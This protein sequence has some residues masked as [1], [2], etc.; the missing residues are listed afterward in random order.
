MAGLS[1]LHLGLPLQSAVD[2]NGSMRP[3]PPESG[4]LEIV[5]VFRMG[6]CKKFHSPVSGYR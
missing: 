1:R 2:L 5:S 4:L 6:Y 3:G